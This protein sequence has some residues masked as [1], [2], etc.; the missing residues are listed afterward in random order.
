M[1]FSPKG[2]VEQ[3]LTLA[4]QDSPRT[5]L[6]KPDPNQ[7]LALSTADP[8]MGSTCAQEQEDDAEMNWAGQRTVKVAGLCLPS[9]VRLNSLS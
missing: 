1:L 6:W 3:E 7:D 8:G 9:H 2:L 5:S 4:H